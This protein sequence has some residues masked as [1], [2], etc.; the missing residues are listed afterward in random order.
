ML[1]LVSRRR[2][3][4][5]Q[6]IPFI[7]RHHAVEA[8]G[9]RTIRRVHRELWR[10]ATHAEVGSSDLLGGS[11]RED[12]DARANSLPTVARDHRSGATRANTTAG[13]VEI[14]AAEGEKQRPVAEDNRVERIHAVKA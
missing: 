10:A 8:I 1:A 5:P 13:G 3:H 12:L 11:H 9:E 4:Q 7:L 2:E 6:A 14:E